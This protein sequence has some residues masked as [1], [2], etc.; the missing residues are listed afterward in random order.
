MGG[1]FEMEQAFPDDAV[2][3]AI[4]GMTGSGKSSFISLLTDDS[5]EVGHSLNS[6]TANVKVY[7]FRDDRGHPGYLIDTPGFDDTTRSDSE[8]LIDIA[9]CFSKLYSRGI[10]LNGLIYLHRITDVRM[11]GSAMKNLTLFKKLCG[12]HAFSNVML[13]T[14]MWDAL[15][16]GRTGDDIGKERLDAL[17]N[18]DKYWGEMERNGSTLARHM[19]NPKSARV[20]VNYLIHKKTKVALDIQ[21]QMVD[22]HLDLNETVAGA[23]L[24]QS[25]VES[26][27]KYEN[28]LDE[29]QRSAD[30]AQEERD[31]DT[32]EML[33]VEEDRY[34]TKMKSASG[35]L[36]KL[37]ISHQ[38]LEKV[39]PEKYRRLIRAIEHE[40]ALRAAE[41]HE[42]E[43]RIADVQARVRRRD[44]EI[45]H[46]TEETDHLAYN[47][48]GKN[49]EL[50]VMRSQLRS[51]SY[52]G[53]KEI[54]SE[55]EGPGIRSDSI[56][57]D[58][59]ASDHVGPSNPA[60][61]NRF[62]MPL[63]RT[64]SSI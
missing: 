58:S 59:V 61:P 20:I 63:T 24:Q 1:K 18:D 14:T 25:L 31:M 49:Q 13:V 21:Q 29:V 48:R 3:I 64:M 52:A 19:G 62:P 17:A 16:P 9:F 53:R 32:V 15:P 57:R 11:Q 41:K 40:R 51:R 45:S 33:R 8:V 34:R 42:F 12:R 55:E 37:R 10:L 7:T 30:L 46:L 60:S 50:D 44:R 22:H 47:L 39:K 35:D 23:Y 28:E 38:A 5:V 27:K 54:H 26:C 43:Q 56:R 36:R 6:C 4:V 2:V